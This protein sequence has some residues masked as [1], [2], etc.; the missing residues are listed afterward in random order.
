MKEKAAIRTALDYV[1]SWVEFQLRYMPFVGAQVAVRYDGELLLDMAVG[2]ADLENDVDLTTDH[3][4][5]IASHSKTFTAV[6]CMQLVEQGK[7]RLD[8]TASDHVPELAKSDMADVTVRELLGHTSGMCRD[9]YDS[10][11]WAL[12]K[13]F[14]S[15]NE[16]LG[17][18]KK[19][20]KILDA[21]E[22]FKYSNIGYSLLGL[23]I[24]GAS[25]QSYREYVQKHIIDAL[26]LKYTGPDIDMD[27]A[28]Q[29]A[30]G[31]SSRIHGPERIEIEHIDTFA[32]SSATGFFSNARDVTEYF[33]AHLD[34]DDR[35]LTDGSKRKMRQKQAS[36]ED[37]GYGLG[38]IISKV[39]DRT[40]Y[41]H[42]G[43][44][45]GHITMSKFD[46]D[47]KLSVSVFTN[48][49]DGPAA[50]LC[51]GILHLIDLATN[52]KGKAKTKPS[53]SKDLKPF[54]GRYATLWGVVDFVNL[55][56]RLYALSPALQNPSAGASELEVLSKT[57]LRNVSDPGYGDYMEKTVFTFTRGGKVKSIK[58]GSGSKLVPIE[59]FTLPDKLRR[60][61]ASNAAE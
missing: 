54:E 4:F 23:I 56:G 25:G 38:L 31:Y 57:E 11:F 61:A 24:E 59:K 51:I 3:H 20:G 52:A 27:R 18:I 42:S 49:A 30:K 39:N 35:I 53:K 26:G 14:P 22:H 34:G 5:R 47:R 32:E 45:P 12:D 40:Y 17:T 58:G 13:P 2:K 33:Q 15:R 43:G 16:L 21:N 41:G 9:G 46:I 36:I 29:L 37:E 50:M 44:Y 28:D 8:D 1:P 7:L 48:S 6:A 19:H 10:T 55:G 60:P